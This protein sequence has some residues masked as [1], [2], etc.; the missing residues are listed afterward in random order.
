MVPRKDLYMPKRGVDLG[1]DWKP[2]LPELQLRKGTRFRS[3][4]LFSFVKSR[5]FLEY[6]I[7]IFK[8]TLTLT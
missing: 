6:I 1:E 8:T 3:K 5:S 2:R 7:L 4:A